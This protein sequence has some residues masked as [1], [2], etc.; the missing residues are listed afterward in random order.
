M[1]EVYEGAKFG[2]DLLEAAYDALDDKSPCKKALKGQK[3]TNQQMAD[4]I[5]KCYKDIDVSEYMLNALWAYALEK[6]GG[7]LERARSYI[8]QVTGMPKAQIRFPRAH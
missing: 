1:S 2:E 4:A 3:P 7:Q 8:S 5:Y 6:F